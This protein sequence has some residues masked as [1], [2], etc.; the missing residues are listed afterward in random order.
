[1]YDGPQEIGI[2]VVGLLTEYSLV[3]FSFTAMSPLDTQ[4]RIE[5][6][7]AEVQQGLEEAESEVKVRTALKVRYCCCADR[8]KIK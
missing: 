4:A 3:P 2:T 8:F 7:E 5:T 6:S 1:M